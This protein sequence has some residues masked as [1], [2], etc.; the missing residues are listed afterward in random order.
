MQTILTQCPRCQTSFKVSDK[1]LAIAA[2][3]VRCGSCLDVFS[4]PAN[5]IVVKQ[6]ASEPLHEE[7]DDSDH[8]N[9]QVVASPSPSNIESAAI[10]ADYVES[11]SP[12]VSGPSV[13]EHEVTTNHGAGETVNP[14][15][16]TPETALESSPGSDEDMEFVLDDDNDDLPLGDMMLDDTA[17]EELAADAF[18]A[19]IHDARNVEGNDAYEDSANNPE[20]ALDVEPDTTAGYEDTLPSDAEVQHISDEEFSQADEASLHE[21][22]SEFHVT[23]LSAQELEEALAASET[24]TAM[25]AGTLAENNLESADEAAVQDAEDSRSTFSTAIDDDDLLDP[26]EDHALADPAEDHELPDAAE[27]FD[28]DDFSGS[29]DMPM[30]DF[31]ALASADMEE[32]ELTAAAAPKP[33]AQ[34]DKEALRQYLAELEDTDALEPLPSATMDSIEV[35]PLTLEVGHGFRKYA[36]T[37]GWIMLSAVLLGALLLQ[38]AAHNLE[39]MQKSPLYSQFLPV[40]CRVLAC[41]Q[42]QRAA[43]VQSLYSEQLL[44]RSHPRVPDALEVSFIFR[45]D[46]DTPQA[47]PLIELSFRDSGS[48]LMANRLFKPEEYLPPELAVL[49]G[50]PASS[51]VQVTLEMTDPGSDA[52]NYEIAFRN[53]ATESLLGP[54][55]PR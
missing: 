15:S 35:D 38:M 31:P 46:A 51:S 39:L 5:R 10:E 43:A 48:R 27:E 41:P 28:D 8:D 13:S 34:R 16:H 36:A 9:E 47:F 45:N 33:H 14:A 42:P 25:F 11:S 19:D 55:R 22:T 17:L 44:V 32:I 52:V 3:M 7:F 26:A 30:E 2:G 1:Q 4:A 53:A 20:S 21:P 49:D 12:A 50:M 29:T 6:A 37:F 40:F 54:Q 23:S 24:P 18:D